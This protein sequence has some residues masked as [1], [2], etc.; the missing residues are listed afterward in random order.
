MQTPRYLVSTVGSTT[1]SWMQT[2][3]SAVVYT[4]CP[5]CSGGW[6]G[7]DTCIISGDVTWCCVGRRAST[8]ENFIIQAVRDE[9]WTHNNAV[10]SFPR[11]VTG[12]SMGLIT[13]LV[14]WFCLSSNGTITVQC[15]LKAARRHFTNNNYIGCRSCSSLR[16]SEM[17][18]SGFKIQFSTSVCFFHLV[19]SLCYAKQSNKKNE[20]KK[21]YT[22]A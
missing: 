18:G 15:I 2:Q 5:N 4:C 3:P 7:R 1:V 13:W 20:G 16:I 9:L 8:L 10:P 21:R 17:A 19:P 11:R 22:F 6:G 12:I 14:S